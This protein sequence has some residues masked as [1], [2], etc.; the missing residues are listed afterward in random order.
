MHQLAGA[1][2]FGFRAMDGSGWLMDSNHVLTSATGV[3]YV[4]PTTSG[5]IPSKIEDPNG[6]FMTINGSWLSDTWGK[7]LPWNY[8][9]TTT[10]LSNCQSNDSSAVLWNFPSV[11]GGTYQIKVCSRA[12]TIQTNFGIKDAL[13]NN[14]EEY[15]PATMTKNTTVVLPDGSSWKFDYLDLSGGD[16]FGN[17]TKITFPTGGS[18]SYAWTT[19]PSP[20]VDG[21]P[22]YSRAVAS[23]TVSDGI[24]SSTWNYAYGSLS[25]GGSVPITYPVTVTD[26]AG[27][28]VVH[29]F[30]YYG[31]GLSPYELTTQY[32]NGSKANNLLL[33]TVNL[34]YG[35]EQDFS[36][37][38]GTYPTNTAPTQIVTTLDDNRQSTVTNS[39][40]TTTSIYDWNYL[41]NE[42]SLGFTQPLI[43]GGAKETDLYD[44]IAGS[45]PGTLLRKVLITYQWQSSS[46]Y[47]NNNLIGIAASSETQAPT[48][49]GP[50]TRCSYASTTYDGATLS[51]SGISTQLDTAPPN[52]SY[53]GNPTSVSHWLASGTISTSANFYDTGMVASTQDAKGNSTSHLYDSTTAGALPT[54][55]TDAAGHTVSATYDWNTGLIL[56]FTDQNS[57]TINVTYDSMLRPIRATFPDGGETDF[58]YPSL[59]EA[60]QK[61]LHVSSPTAS[62]IFTH[63]YFDGLGRTKQ[64]RIEDP[65]GDVY[66]D[67]TYDGMGRVATVSNPYRTTSDSTYGVTTTNYDALGRTIKV[68]P[69]DGTSTTDNIGTSYSGS[70]STVTDQSG[71]QRKSYFDALS[72]LIEVDEPGAIVP[73]TPG[74]GSLTV[75]GTEQTST[76]SG[77]SATSA[78]G[79]VTINGSEQSV[80]TCDV[81]C[82]TTNDI[83]TVSITVNGFTKS[84]NYGAS[85]TTTSLASA[86]SS[87]FNSDSTSPV[88]A[89]SSN[90]VVT[91]T[92]KATGS[93]ANYSLSATSSTSDP[94][95][96]AAASFTTSTS[97]SSLTGGKNA[98]AGGTVY[99]TGTVTATV[100]GF[101]A[102]ASYGQGS[103]TSSIASSLATALSASNSP[104]TATVSGSTVSL[105]SKATGSSSN[106]SLSITSSTSQPSAFASASFGGTLS[107]ST[108]TGG[109]DQG[110]GLSTPLKTYYS[111]DGLGN[112]TQVNQTGTSGDT[113]RVR[114]FTYDGLSRMLTSN[115]PESGQISY[116]YPV[117]GSL[118]SGSLSAPCSKTDARGVTVTYGYADPLNRLT[119]KTYSGTPSAL[120]VHLVYDTPSGS[121]AFPSGYPAPGTSTWNTGRL[122]GEQVNGAT[123]AVYAYDKMGREDWNQQCMGTV[124]KTNSAVFNLDGSPASVSLPSILAGNR[125]LTY[126]YDSGATYSGTGTAGHLVSVADTA[127]GITFAQSALY[128]ANGSLTG[129]NMGANGS[130]TGINVTNSY[131]KRFQP[132]SMIASGPSAS[133]LN[134]TYNFALGAND[135]GNVYS[136]TNNSDANRSVTYTYDQLNR[137]ITAQTPNTDCTLTGVSGSITKNWG[138]SFSYD[139]FGNLLGKTVTKCSAESLTT[140]Y[141]ANNR[142]S[143]GVTYNYDAAGNMI[144]NGSATYTY[145]A[146][147]RVTQAGGVS[148]VYDAQ[149]R[150]VSKSS[151]TTYW[152]DGS[153]VNLE[154]D[155]AGNPQREYIYFGSE[156]IARIDVGG[157]IHYYISDHLH[158]TSK[159]VSSAGALEN[160]SDYFP[161]GGERQYLASVGDQHFKFTGKERDAESGLDYFG[162]RYYSSI[163]GRWMS[164][165]WS[166]DSSPIP[167]ATMNSPQTLNLY[168]YVNNNPTT[169]VDILGHDPTPPSGPGAGTTANGS[170]INWGCSISND[171]VCVP[172]PE[173]ISD[174]AAA[175]QQGAANAQTQ[176]AQ[177]QATSSPAPALTPAN[178][179]AGKYLKEEVKGVGD[180]TVAPIASMV[181]HPV[182]TV[183]DAV[184]GFSLM[185]NGSALKEVGNEVVTEMKSKV[186]ELAAGDPRAVGQLVGT[187]AAAAYTAKNL[188]AGEYEHG[189]GGVN[190][191]NTPTTGSRIGFDLHSIPESGGGIRPHIDITI[192]KPGV[193]SGPGSNLLNIKHWPW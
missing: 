165:D 15:G 140:S 68:I 24:T 102:S 149:G 191:L 178:M 184:Q 45:S 33:K 119:D 10:D 176:T 108:L 116:T 19:I 181:L 172:V 83:G 70:T 171:F 174:G 85:S 106:Y 14:V 25:G 180:A 103:T 167:Y 182:Q 46:N 141:A 77:T 143:D 121:F 23:R 47:K 6:N 38:N 104:V 179:T 146:E 152:Y 59:T 63:A 124:C 107:G 48:C 91:L 3:H 94:G 192:K 17:L 157:A 31:A 156:R 125:T 112:L 168:A 114:T 109:A 32:Y 110:G 169:D 76:T 86:L 144:K 123:T 87:A 89:S 26:P 64:T 74:N 131:D 57:Q 7:E 122:I 44:Y 13:G 81:K 155:L 21:S 29:S 159:V 136:V 16:N 166:D 117:S 138:E 71:K 151:G 75:T 105:I 1:V 150:R 161:F 35:L 187:L 8:S 101:A 139:S 62:W 37:S 133:Y 153:A 69:P 188:N 177:D 34:T 67:T 145:D 135:N 22:A 53:R 164:P 137:L 36:D 49:S 129:L 73:A 134:L 158:S 97:G 43:V 41:Q 90:N 120:P 173:L 82:T 11:G 12:Y 115:N 193:P 66:T 96:F 80:Q 92:S 186:A 130:F 132:V 113:A 99:D 170:E 183:K 2:D 4:P 79:S 56:S 72:H 93:S 40:D 50:N 147:N 61:V 5:L 95:D 52:G 98:V 100:G 78:S 65:V 88:T 27:N 162:A 142:F 127:N 160:D 51:S 20:S 28:D 128:A 185:G 18:I 55:T 189:G 163:M 175:G 58:S 84:V 118:C 39:Y 60:L 148:Y 154:S 126:T 54:Q 111:Y 30:T 42:G 190:I 9:T